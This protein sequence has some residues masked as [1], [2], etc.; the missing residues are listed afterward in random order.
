MGWRGRGR[1]RG[2]IL[3]KGMTDKG[4]MCIHPL[5]THTHTSCWLGCKNWACASAKG[6][7]AL[8][9]SAVNTNEG[10]RGRFV[11]TNMRTRLTTVSSMLTREL[12]RLGV[13]TAGPRGRDCR[14]EGSSCVCGGE[15]GL[16]VEQTMRVQGLVTYSVCGG[17]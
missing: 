14:I 13:T 10:N 12:L 9:S 2:G 5:D 1:G 7:C 6:P 4:M 15:G 17:E 3:G 11:L 8:M 16:C